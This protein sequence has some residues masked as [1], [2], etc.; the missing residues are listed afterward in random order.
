MTS[1][2]QPWDLVFE[3]MF[4]FLDRV[5]VSPGADFIF[6]H[7]LSREE[8]SVAIDDGCR[9]GCPDALSM[10]I[11]QMNLISGFGSRQTS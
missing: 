11:T 5:H 1:T 7:F 6:Q 3:E 10:T 8:E 2:K 4:V 9:P